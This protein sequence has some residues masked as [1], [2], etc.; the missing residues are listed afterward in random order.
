MLESDVLEAIQN[1]DD[2]LRKYNAIASA[3]FHVGGKLIPNYYDAA[4][5][6]DLSV[7]DLHELAVKEHTTLIETIAEGV[8]YDLLTGPFSGLDV[9]I[10]ENQELQ[11]DISRHPRGS[12][13]YLPF[14]FGGRAFFFENRLRATLNTYQTHFQGRSIDAVIDMLYEANRAVEFKFRG[15]QV[16]LVAPKSKLEFATVNRADLTILHGELYSLPLPE[17]LSG[18]RVEKLKFGSLQ[19]LFLDKLFPMAITSTTF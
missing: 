10:A 5:L 6:A 1:P 4:Y 12:R 8:R 9:L 19:A 17:E 3:L 14:G 15:L 11:R 13:V 16:Q 2:L 18:V 7:R